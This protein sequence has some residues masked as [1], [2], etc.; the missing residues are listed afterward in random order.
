MIGLI[1]QIRDIPAPDIHRRLTRYYLGLGAEPHHFRY[2]YIPYH[3]FFRISGNSGPGLRI[4]VPPEVDK[5]KNNQKVTDKSQ[6]NIDG[7]LQVFH[8]HRP[9]NH[10]IFSHNAPPCHLFTLPAALSPFPDKFS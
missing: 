5:H 9:V 1:H 3:L 4:H 10:C 2:H 6:Y 7:V 8:Q